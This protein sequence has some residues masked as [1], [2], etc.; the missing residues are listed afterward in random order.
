MRGRG[1][2]PLVAF[3]VIAVALGH[4]N[5]ATTQAAYPDPGS[6]TIRLWMRPPVEGIG[7][8]ACL[9]QSWHEPEPTAYDPLRALDWKAGNSAD[10]SCAFIG[11]ETVYFRVLA[12]DLSQAYDGTSWQAMYAVKSN[13]P[14]NQCPDGFQ[15]RL[16]KVKIWDYLGTSHGYMIFAHS[17][18]TS[19]DFDINTKFVEGVNARDWAYAASWAIGDTVQDGPS[20]GTGACW[21]GWHAH[22]VNNDGGAWDNWNSDYDYVAPPSCNCYNTSDRANWTRRMTFTVL[23]E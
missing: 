15:V 5:V 14:T 22:E 4:A 9:T 2:L 20:D 12:A 18:L 1:S 17:V 10:T 21:S 19:G 16:G 8:K 11:S 23:V 7:Q 13:L 3:S 6:H